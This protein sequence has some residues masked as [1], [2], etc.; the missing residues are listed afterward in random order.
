MNLV[1]TAGDE[2]KLTATMESLQSFGLQKQAQTL[3]LTCSSLRSVPRAGE[4]DAYT[5]LFPYPNAWTDSYLL[6][7]CA[8]SCNAPFPESEIILGCVRI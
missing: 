3:V 5:I 1:T 4:I 6:A 2:I 7:P 8:C